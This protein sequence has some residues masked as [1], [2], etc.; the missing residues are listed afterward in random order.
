MVFS[1]NLKEID[2]SFFFSQIKDAV[3]LCEYFTWL[4]H[5]VTEGSVTEM[6]AAEKLES[7]KK[8]VVYGLI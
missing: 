2:F 1:R 8:Y 4:S 6:S 7:F 3:A 5:E